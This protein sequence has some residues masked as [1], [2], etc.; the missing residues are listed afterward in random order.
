VDFLKTFRRVH[1]YDG[2]SCGRALR[3]G[4]IVQIIDVEKDPGFA[5]YRMDSARAGFR[6]VQ[7]ASFL[8]KDG[9]LM[10]VV[11]DAFRHPHR[12]S[13]L[14]VEILRG[15]YRAVAADHVFQLLGDV[16]LGEKAEQMSERL[17]NSISIS[18]DPTS[19]NRPRDAQ[20]T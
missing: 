19:K 10:G 9:R 11:L 6:S 16:S 8:T 12:P 7:T 20:L 15:G 14:E 3:S 5:A 4:E 17:Y 13:K 18:Q 1:S 2:T